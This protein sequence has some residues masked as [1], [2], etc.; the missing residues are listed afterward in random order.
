M[1]FSISYPET[2]RQFVYIPKI[3]HLT[4]GTGRCAA[5]PTDFARTPTASRPRGSAVRSCLS[6]LAV[7]MKLQGTAREFPLS[8]R[9]GYC[10]IHVCGAEQGVP[11][12]GASSNKFCIF[13]SPPAWGSLVMI[14]VNTV[15][16]GD[17][18][19]NSGGQHSC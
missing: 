10:A 2:K 3:G 7:A 8:F 15:A 9:V 18:G 1:L 12:N 14:V 6:R 19:S 5:K 16:E 4:A 11:I 13:R 17:S